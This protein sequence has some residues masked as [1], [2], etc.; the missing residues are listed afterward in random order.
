MTGPDGRPATRPALRQIT[1]LAA[2]MLAPNPSPMTLSGTNSWVLRGAGD[3]SVIVDPG[4]D[5]EA[6]LVALADTRPALIL[7]THRHPDHSAGATRLR[8]LTGAPV[9]AADA[10]C[11][12][13]APPLA[14]EIRAEGLVIGVLPTPGHTADSV[15]F[16]VG[17]AVLTGDTILGRGTT[18]IAPPDGDLGD[19]LRS[20]ETLHA[21]GAR[22]VLPGHGPVLPD[23]AAA[24]TRYLAHRHERLAEVRRVLASLGS[25]ATVDAV[26][27][28]VYAGAEGQ[29]RRA[30]EWSVRA[31]L[32]YLRDDAPTA[33]P[34]RRARSADSAGLRGGLAGKA[35]Q[36]RGS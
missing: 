33:A 19:Y 5:D 27:D 16:A 25:A 12:A 11:C 28:R 26:T 34:T 13:A 20:L 3:H 22:T 30:A 24:A 4:P 31:Q 8:S 14:G 7:L 2:L 35:R 6:H 10:A 29:L 15:C 32:D 18:V 17:A 23:L 9:R 1:D 21:L 36:D